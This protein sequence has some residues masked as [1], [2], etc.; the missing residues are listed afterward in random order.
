MIIVSTRQI[1]DLPDPGDAPFLEVSI[2]AQVPLV[3]G[4]TRQSPD[5]KTRGAVVETPTEFIARIAAAQAP[6]TGEKHPP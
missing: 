4:N 6:L 2:E 3:T 5:P 1:L